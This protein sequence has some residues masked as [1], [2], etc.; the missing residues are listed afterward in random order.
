MSSPVLV[1]VHDLHTT[2][3][4]IPYKF[5]WYINMRIYESQKKFSHKI[6]NILINF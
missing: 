1:Y 4:V 3:H 2:D 5:L 6:L